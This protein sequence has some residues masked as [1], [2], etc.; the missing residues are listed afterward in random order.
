MR[1]EPIIEYNNSKFNI[2]G[3]E[4]LADFPQLIV[5]EDID[6]RIFKLNINLLQEEVKASNIYYHLNLSGKTV[7]RY[8]QEILEELQK[9]KREKIIIELTED[10]IKE[11]EEILKFFLANNIKVSLDDFGT[12]SSNFD[13]LFRYKDVVENI[14]ID[15]I[16]WVNMLNVV[17]EIINFCNENSIDVIFE[18]VEKK[19]ELDRLVKIGGKFFQGWY[20]K[21]HFFRNTIR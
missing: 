11:E 7:L 18:K 5:N 3:Y 20:F 4:I 1:K 2:Y 13:R 21:D 16:L 12:L 10:S 6:F 15:K 19:E 8:K 14:K 17:K 9:L